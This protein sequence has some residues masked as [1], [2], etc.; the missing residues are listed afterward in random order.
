MAFFR[1]HWGG[2]GKWQHF[3][4]LSPSWI[5]SFL[6]PQIQDGGWKQCYHVPPQPRWGK[7]THPRSW[8]T[9]FPMQPSWMQDGGTE[10]DVCMMS[11]L[12]WRRLTDFCPMPW[13]I[14]KRSPQ[15]NICPVDVWL[16]TEKHLIASLTQPLSK[17]LRE[18]PACHYGE[19]DQSAWV[20]TMENWFWLLAST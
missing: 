14:G 10:N 7:K 1:S 16:K 19:V 11:R 12:P 20:K 6:I 15:S 8:M 17:W 4:F 5:I 13:V 2:C 3:C 9:S 18:L